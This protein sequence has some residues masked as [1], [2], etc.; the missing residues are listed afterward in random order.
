MI[1]PSSEDSSNTLQ[2]M[3]AHPYVCCTVCLNLNNFPVKYRLWEFGIYIIK[4]PCNHK[5]H[6]HEIM[7]CNDSAE[8]VSRFGDIRPL[9][10]KTLL[11]SLIV[12]FKFQAVKYFS[13]YFYFMQSNS[14]QAE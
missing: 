2:A 3:N 4:S 10:T 1:N 13:T 8:H 9:C 11:H 14:N 6:T 5:L 7:T 12:S